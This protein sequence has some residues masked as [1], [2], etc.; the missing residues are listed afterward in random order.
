MLTDSLFKESLLA[1]DYVP[2][3]RAGRWEWRPLVRRRLEQ[4]RAAHRV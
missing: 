1:D 4:A 2:N 3:R